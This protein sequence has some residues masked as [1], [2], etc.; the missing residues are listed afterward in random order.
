MRNYEGS[1]G[2]IDQDPYSSQPPDLQ[3]F[4]EIQFLEREQVRIL[5]HNRR[6][7]LLVILCPRLEEWIIEASKEANVELN[8]YS[9]PN[10]PY[11]L[12]DIINVSL[13]K[14]Q[15]LVEDLMRRSNRIR[16]LRDY[17]GRRRRN[18]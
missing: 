17:L 8:S 9:L 12:H 7:N 2:M 14:F 1:I 13:D 11:E 16:T 15:Q 6:N 4:T 10:D 18:M 5:R 3:R